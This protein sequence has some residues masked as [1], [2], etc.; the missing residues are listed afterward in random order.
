MYYVLL[1]S[2]SLWDIHSLL[3]GLLWDVAQINENFIYYC[4]ADHRSRMSCLCLCVCKSNKM[5]QN[6]E[7]S[8]NHLTQFKENRKTY[9]SPS[10]PGS[11][12]LC[13]STIS[14]N[15]FHT[16]PLSSTQSYTFLSICMFLYVRISNTIASD[17]VCPRNN[18][19]YTPSQYLRIKPTA[20]PPAHR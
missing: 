10:F 9:P 20:P 3:L 14:I 17:I 4:D 8:K 15:L 1:F 7:L 2:L 11:P 6:A 16:S 18:Y 12:G 13:R 19:C 5:S